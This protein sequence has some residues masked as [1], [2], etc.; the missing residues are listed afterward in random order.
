MTNEV[1]NPDMLRI[2]RQACGLSQQALSKRTK[3][4]QADLSR[5]ENG[6]LE[7]NNETLR[8]FSTVLGF[9]HGFFFQTG[10]IVGPPLSIQY[11]K[12][13]RSSQYAVGLLEAEINIRT[14]HIRRLLDAANLKTTLALP[15]LELEDYGCDPAR[16]AA[17][18]RRLWFLPTGPIRNLVTIL[19]NAGCIAIPC[20]FTKL[21]I[22]AFTVQVA[23]LPPCIFFDRAMP[24]D[25][26]RFA[27]AHEL[28]HLVM[29]QFPAVEMELEADAFAA[30]FLMPKE[31]LQPDL[32]GPGRRVTIPR[33]AT[34][35]RV[36]RVS[37]AALL[38]RAREIGAITPHQS[39][40]LWRQMNARGFRNV[41]PPTADVP[42]EEPTA[43][44]KLLK[45]H[46]DDLGYKLDDVAAILKSSVEDLHQKYPLPNA[47]SHLR[48]VK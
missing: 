34:L 41:E 39:K 32:T 3:V 22:D 44:A 20:D 21:N 36:W 31:D 17:M 35:K 8:N 26:Q 19:E 37:M 12:R 25:R 43:L 10:S 29:H 5:L 11:R 30:A 1:F 23:D 45:V 6:L 38:H 48:L 33:L 24:G 46:F 40:D 4:S 2:A 9:P 16:L 27:L 18:V 42:R 28:G 47:N 13:R 7:P 15:S 14:L